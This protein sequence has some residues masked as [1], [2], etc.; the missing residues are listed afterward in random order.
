MRRLLLGVLLSGC[1]VPTGPTNPSPAPLSLHEQPVTTEIVAEEEEPQETTIPGVPSGFDAIDRF[2]DMSMA[3]SVTVAEQ[4]EN[5][6]H[7]RAIV[8]W[9]EHRTYHASRYVTIVSRVDGSQIHDRDRPTAWRFYTRLTAAGVL[10]PATCP[11]HQIDPNET[12]TETSGPP[13][14][15]R[16]S[17]RE[18][19]RSWP[20]TRTNLSDTIRDQWLRHPHGMEEFGARGPHDWN[21]NAFRHLPGCWDPAML[22]RFDVA[23]FVTVTAANKICQRYGCRDKWAIKAHWGRRARP[24]RGSTPRAENR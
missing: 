23:A 14:K 2:D 15:R 18:L 24:Y 3:C 20:F 4:V 1:T 5:P 10:D 8:D 6:V 13:R 19:A 21:A 11:Y 12:H 7:A 22:E 16:A 9:C 17:C